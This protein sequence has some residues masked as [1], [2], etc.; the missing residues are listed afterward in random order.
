[1]LSALIRG[2]FDPGRA[3]ASIKVT[4][5]TAPPSIP[6]IAA[7]DLADRDQHDVDSIADQSAGRFSPRGPHGMFYRRG[8]L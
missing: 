8:N 6:S 5:A 3:H 4:A 2:L 7:A 1:M